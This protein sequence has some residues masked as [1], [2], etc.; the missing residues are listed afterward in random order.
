MTYT[1]K[2]KTIDVTKKY[3]IRF[4]KIALDKGYITEEQLYE[5]IRLQVEDDIKR[6]PHRVLGRILFEMG[7]MSTKEIDDVLNEL[8]KQK[9]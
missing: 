6:R 2:N 9:Q 8:F 4:G 7:V 5:A 1:K 3:C